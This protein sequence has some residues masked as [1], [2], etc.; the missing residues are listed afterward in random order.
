MPQDLPE[1]RNT[2]K[3]RKPWTF[4]RVVKTGFLLFAGVMVWD[5]VTPRWAH[6]IPHYVHYTCMDGEDVSTA[7]DRWT[8]APKETKAALCVG[9][10]HPKPAAASPKSCLPGADAA[11]TG[12]G[13]IPD[14]A[15][16]Q[17]SAPKG[18][19]GPDLMLID[20]VTYEYGFAKVT[21]TVKNVGDDDAF[22][23]IIKMEV[24]DDTGQTLLAQDEGIY[25]AGQLFTHMKPGISAGFEGS[26]HVP[27][28]PSRI[29]VRVSVEKFPY[30]E[31][32]K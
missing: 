8:N 6:I 4:K 31:I 24:Y 14:P 1:V 26:A 25:P 30:Q 15:E 9:H 27:G 3:P 12:T 2:P 10:N 18:K 16:A 29:R 23:P 28:E 7:T 19:Q 13:G 17:P 22:S 32:R 21:G 5:I 20:H 11:C